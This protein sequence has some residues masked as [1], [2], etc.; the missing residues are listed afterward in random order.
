MIPVRYVWLT[1]SGLFFLVW[2]V[3]FARYRRYRQLMWWF[4]LLAAPFGFSEPFF[5]LHYW[6][7]PSMFNLTH[8][9]RACSSKSR[10]SS[11]ERSR[12]LAVL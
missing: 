12:D 4:S 7:P 11:S 8:T 5:L 6:H 2:L 1:W 9:D 3:L 10:G